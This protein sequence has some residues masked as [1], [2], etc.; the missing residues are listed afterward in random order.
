MAEKPEKIP[1]P[2]LRT[3]VEQYS[4]VERFKLESNGVRG[5]MREE[6]RDHGGLGHHR[7]LY[8]EVVHVPLVLRWPDRFRPARVDEPVSL[9]DVPATIAAAAGARLEGPG[10]SLLDAASGRDWTSPKAILSGA[11][12]RRCY[13]YRG[14]RPPPRGAFRHRRTS[15]ACRPLRLSS[16][17]VSR[18]R[19]ADCPKDRSGKATAPCRRS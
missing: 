4:G 14:M 7:T 17:C 13:E 12:I 15:T 9:I 10:Q 6:F 19:M 3:P 5:T 11:F 8:Q 2:N 16:A 1:Q 18:R